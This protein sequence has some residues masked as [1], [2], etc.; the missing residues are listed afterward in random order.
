MTGDCCYFVPG[1]DEGV[2]D[3][4]AKV[5]GC[6]YAEGMIDDQG[7]YGGYHELNQKSDYQVMGSAVELTPNT[8][9][10]SMLVILTSLGLFLNMVESL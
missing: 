1:L 7:Q 10:L 5:S 3:G 2:G 6:L 9:T 8:A 4:A